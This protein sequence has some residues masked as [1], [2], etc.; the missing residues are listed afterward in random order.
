MDCQFSFGPNNAYFLKSD[1]WR[2]WSDNNT[3]PEPLRRVLE[4]PDNPE[5][6]KFPYD[7]AH[8]IP[9]GPYKAS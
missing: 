7:V 5:Y 2:A 6:C 8:P 3:I 1:S 9:A 4:D